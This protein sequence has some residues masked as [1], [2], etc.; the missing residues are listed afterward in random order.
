[1]I[2]TPDAS[3]G[4]GYV[5]S[6]LA[7]K[8]WPDIQYTLVHADA[9]LPMFAQAHNVKS[10]L[11]ASYGAP[12]ASKSSFAIAMVLG[13]GRSRGQVR[14]KSKNPQDKPIIDAN[15]FSHP[16]DMKIFVDGMRIAVDLVESTEAYGKIDG[17]FATTALPGCEHFSSPEELRSDAYYEC[18]LRQLSFTVHHPSCTVPMG[19]SQYDDDYPAVLDS[20]LRV[21]K[22]KRLRVIDASIMPRIPNANLNAPTIMIGEKGAFFIR[23]YWASQY[24]VCVSWEYLTFRENSMCFYY[25]L[26]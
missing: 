23:E 3:A 6:S 2:S 10:E 7:E 4:V 14:L 24:E 20:K 22:T 15:Y 1:L 21:F 13:L 11:W 18:Y 17:K 9:L 19:K 16:D 5:C 8:D 25:R 12:Y 26:P